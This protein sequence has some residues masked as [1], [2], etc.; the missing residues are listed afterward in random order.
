MMLDFKKILEKWLPFGSTYDHRDSVFLSFRGIDTRNSFTDH[1]HKALV[2][3]NIRTILDDREIHTGEELK[4]ELENAIKASRAS[5]IVLST[6]YASSTW[7]LDELVLILEQ[8]RTSKHIVI[9][10]FYHV[11]PSNVRYRQSSFGDAFIKHKEMIDAEK[12][13]TKKREKT[14]KLKQWKKAVTEVACLKGKNASGWPETRLIDEVVKEIKLGFELHKK[15]EHPYLTWMWSSIATITWFLRYV[16]MCIIQ[17]LLMCGA[18]FMT[19]YFVDHPPAH[20][21][22][23][24]LQK[25]NLQQNGEDG[26]TQTRDTKEDT[27]R[28]DHLSAPPP[29]DL[30]ANTRKIVP[31]YLQ[32]R[33]LMYR[34]DPRTSA[35]NF[36]CE[37][38]QDLRDNG[39]RSLRQTHGVEEGT[40]RMASTRKINPNY[41]QTSM[42]MSRHY[43]RT[44][45]VDFQLLT[46]WAQKQD[47]QEYQKR[48]WT[49]THVFEG[50]SFRRASTKN[51]NPNYSQTR[52]LMSRL[53]PKTSPVYFQLLAAWAQTQYL[54]E[55]GKQSLTQKHAVKEDSF[56]KAY[57]MKINPNYPQTLALMSKHDLRT[58]PVDF[59]LLTALA[60]KQY[61]QENGIPSLTQT[62]GVEEESF[63]KIHPNYP[64]TMALMSRL[65]PRTSHVDSQMFYLLGMHTRTRLKK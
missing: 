5:I 38:K 55:N 4:P 65:D 24:R 17:F 63:G 33:K 49:Q 28:E 43:P 11:Q 13:A 35:V 53:N 58:S 1:I 40:F 31:S 44:S 47:L 59:Q 9:P 54:Q 25:R 62:H 8:R 64:Q 16:C 29:I 36:G 52:M 39:K 45:P 30:M 22:P 46:T 51:I 3:A 60:Q 18:A 50:V 20:A 12:N 61:L 48:S 23:L 6:N 27:S 7:C 57:T 21:L 34:L 15:S 19:T 41:H 56:R 2:D 32:S 10:I 42:L 26:L 37:Q 14:C